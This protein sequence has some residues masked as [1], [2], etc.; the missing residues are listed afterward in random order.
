MYL[1]QFWDKRPIPEEIEILMQ[2][3]RTRNPDLQHRCFD[4]AQADDFIARHFSRRHLDA[5]RSCAVPA[6][7]ADYLRYCA[8]LVD[9]GFYADADAKCV[10][11]V[12]ALMPPGVDGIVFQKANGIVINNFFGFRNPRH[13]LLETVLE[14]ATT[15]IERRA[16]GEDIWLTTGPGLFTFLWVISASTLQEREELYKEGESADQKTRCT[17]LCRDVALRVLGT[18]DGIFANI[19]TCSVNEL[20][21]FSQTVHLKYKETRRHWVNWKGSIFKEPGEVSD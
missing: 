6:M 2:S 3:Y 7:Q 4:R 18:V 12:A 13:P 19:S 17:R 10:R 8:V 21:E 5:F 1:T 20:E 15:A 14:I 16:C 11:P 9:G